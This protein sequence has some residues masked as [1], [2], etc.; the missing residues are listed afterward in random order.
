[1][2]CD[3]DDDGG[4]TIDD[5]DGESD[6]IMVMMIMMMICNGDDD[7]DDRKVVTCFGLGMMMTPCVQSCVVGGVCAARRW[8]LHRACCIFLAARD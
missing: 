4:G 7:D 2:C 6:Y 1:M 3:H 8:Q 5:N